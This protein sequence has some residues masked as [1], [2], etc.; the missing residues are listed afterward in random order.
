MVQGSVNHLRYVR[1][2]IWILQV[3]VC[4]SVCGVRNDTL[5]LAQSLCYASRILMAIVY[6][7]IVISN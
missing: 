7:K 1:Y 2:N 4:V 5:A 3:Y 6:T